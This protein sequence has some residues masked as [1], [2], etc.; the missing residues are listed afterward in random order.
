MNLLEGQ[1][2]SSRRRYGAPLAGAE[3]AGNCPRCLSALLLGDDP[4]GHLE[5]TS[6]P[7]LRRVGNYELPEEIARGG[8]G[9]VFR[10]CQIGL[11]R[12]VALKLLRGS[13]L[14][15]PEEVKRFR[16]E[17]AAVAR[18]NHPNIV[19]I[20]EVGEDKGQHYLAMDLVTGPNLAQF[21]RDGPLNSGI[22]K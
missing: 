2:N 14:A 4:S 11:D 10:A 19:A 5:F 7:V 20:H 9:I 1:P 15:Q 17:A 13:T 8:M 22:A 12:I 18:L 21:N 3:L 6:T 16:A